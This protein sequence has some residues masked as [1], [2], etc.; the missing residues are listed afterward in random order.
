MVFGV[1]A[2]QGYCLTLSLSSPP[3][4]PQTVMVY[5]TLMECKIHYRQK[6]ISDQKPKNILCKPLELGTSQIPAGVKR[7][8]N[9][10]AVNSWL[11]VLHCELVSRNE[12]DLAL[13]EGTTVKI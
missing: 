13:K 7:S 1:L 5:G 4:K 6:E 3:L 12:E 10:N 9:G 11:D 2:I 8:V